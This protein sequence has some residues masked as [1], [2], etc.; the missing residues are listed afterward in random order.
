[1][2]ECVGKLKQLWRYPVKSMVGETLAQGYINANGL[3]GDRCWAFRDEAAAQLTVVRDTPRLLQCKARYLFEPDADVIPDV[4][5]TFPGGTEVSSQ[6]PA[7]SQLMSEWLGKEVT[8]WPLQ[9]RAKWRHYRL[10]SVAS[11]KDLKRQFASQTLPNLSSFP[12]PLLLQLSAFV[13][14]PGHYYDA[15]PLHIVTS[16]SLEKLREIEPQGDFRVERFRPNILI[17]S[18]PG[19]AGFD[20][21]DWVEG[22]LH[23]GK[24]VIH[25]ESPTV[26]CSM[27]SQPQAGLAKDSKVVRTL[28]QHAD[29]DLG[30][31]ASVIVAGRIKVGDDVI[32]FPQKTG[33]LRKRF[34]PIADGFKNRSMHTTLSALDWIGRKR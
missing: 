10:G 20:E 30:V 7:A 34:K 33:I 15:F 11:A 28:V 14:P 31:N 22:K 23:I 9:P 27:P 3:R 24:T 32:W 25:V 26:R 29:R 19:P 13:T 18:A 16:H 12:W 6:N 21:L 1:M 17:E 5:M 2:S 4:M 8:L